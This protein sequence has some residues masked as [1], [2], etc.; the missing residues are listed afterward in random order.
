MNLEAHRDIMKKWQTCPP[1]ATETFISDGPIDP[2]RWIKIERRVLFL[3]K[4]AYGETGPGTTWD[5]PKLVRE[6]WKEPKGKFWWSLGYWAYGIQRL[7]EGP[8][9]SSPMV[10]KR[11]DE[12]TEAML[13]SAVVNIKKSCGRSASS[14]DDLLQYVVTDGALLKKQVA[15]LSPHVVICCKTWHLVKDLWPHAKPISEQVHTIDDMLVL[16]F[17]HPANH[18]PNVMN[19]YTALVLIHRALY[20]C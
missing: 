2:N 10:N 7:T 19:Y 15:Y 17:W 5:L 1:H 4:E 8:I 12:V 3:A 20:P 18:Y 6:E 14:D 13:A 9:P 11:W 16:D